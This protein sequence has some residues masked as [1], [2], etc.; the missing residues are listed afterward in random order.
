MVAFRPFRTS[1]RPWVTE[2]N[3]RFYQTVHDFDASFADAVRDALDLLESQNSEPASNYVIAEASNTPVGC[4]FLSLEA[5]AVER[6]LHTVSVSTF[7]RHPEACRLY[8]AFGFELLA[9]SRT[10]AFGH[11]MQQL[12]YAL[13]LADGDR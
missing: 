3:V 2:A 6:I 11:V 10:L 12:D 5:P 4:I 13:S 1:D 9:K 7:D 8:E